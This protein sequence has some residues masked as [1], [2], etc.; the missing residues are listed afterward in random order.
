[1]IQMKNIDFSYEWVA[2]EWKAHSEDV[3]KKEAASVTD[4]LLLLHG[5]YSSVLSLHDPDHYTFQ[6]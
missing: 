3:I 6:D 5:S 1:M 4:M 2:G